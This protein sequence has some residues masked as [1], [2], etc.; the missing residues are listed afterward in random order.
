MQ[1]QNKEN[2]M[3]KFLNTELESELELQSDTELE[4]K[5]ELESDSESNFLLIAMLCFKQFIDGCFLDGCFLDGCLLTLNKSKKLVV[6]FLNLNKSK[7]SGYFSDLE[8][9]KKFLQAN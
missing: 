7:N 3:S 9:L 1:I 4:S 6:I 2:K 8:Q 5:S